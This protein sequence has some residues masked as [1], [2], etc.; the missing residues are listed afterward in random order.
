MVSYIYWRLQVFLISVERE[1][2][3]RVTA[4]GGHQ[5]SAIYYN[6][7]SFW[8]VHVGGTKVI[9]LSFWLEGLS[10][11]TLLKMGIMAIDLVN[12]N[13]RLSS[14]R[15]ATAISRHQGYLLISG[16][17]ESLWWVTAIDGHQGI[18]IS[19]WRESS[20][21]GTAKG[22]HHGQRTF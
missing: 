11:A 21:W 15:W 5:V 9:C 8:W 1:C 10:M 16:L 13:W 20:W 3:Y 19:G 2:F 12:Y 4:R 7:E 14:W 22:G 18:L 6:M 17:R